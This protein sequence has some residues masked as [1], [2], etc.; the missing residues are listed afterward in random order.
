MKRT[1]YPPATPCARLLAHPAVTEESKSKLQCQRGQLDPVELLHRIRQGQAALAALTSADGAVKGPGRQTL[2]QYLSRLP[3]LW[4][5]GEVRPTH[6]SGPAPLRHWRTR[7]DPFEA[8][9]LDVLR[10]LQGDPDATAKA[11]FAH[12]QAEYPA[13][14]PDS[15]LRTLQRRVR[16]WR[17]IMARKLVYAC[18]EPNGE[19]AEVAPVGAGAAPYSCAIWQWPDT[20]AY[21]WGGGAGWQA[22]GGRSPSGACQ[23]AGRTNRRRT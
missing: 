15:Q 16:E 18:M 12:L 23:P 14:F 22:P 8:V 21:G 20:V 3:E 11:L 6:H 13:R 17:R 2:D 10:W 9:W 4:R 19:G 1:Y 5:S 7:Q